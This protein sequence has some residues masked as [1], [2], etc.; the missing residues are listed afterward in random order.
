MAFKLLLISVEGTIVGPSDIIDRKIAQQLGALAAKL[1]GRGVTVALWSTRSWTYNGVSLE[2]YMSKYAEVEIQAHGFQSDRSPPRRRAGSADPILSKYG[3][4]RSEA[5]LLGGSEEDMIAGVQNKLLHIRCDWYGKQTEYGLFAAAD[6]AAVQRFC[7]VFALRQ[8]SIFWRHADSELDVTAAGPFSTKSEAYA[9]FGVDARDAAKHGSGHPEFWFLITASSLYFSGSLT[10]VD[11]ICSYPGHKA[12]ARGIEDGSQAAVLARLGQCLRINY[13]HDLIE[14][15]R[16][17][18]KSQFKKAYE[19][20]FLNQINTIRLNPNPH[21]NFSPTPNKK[22]VSLSGKTILVVDDITTSGKSLDSARAY[23]EAAGGKA[24]LFSWLKTINSD[25]TRME[26]PKISPWQVNSFAV[27]PN[28]VTYSYDGGIVD[29]S[30]P[31]ELD[32]ALKLFKAL[33]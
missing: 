12:A 28:F 13:Y 14:R 17:A 4:K 3:V 19:R 10:G 30:A 5:V 18:E 32:A 31:E 20:S 33:S 15:H 26:S 27:E 2:N 6:V 9:M 1:S 29:D 7:L 16:D 21:R 8:H 24:R 22:R 11:Y 25:Y 23:I